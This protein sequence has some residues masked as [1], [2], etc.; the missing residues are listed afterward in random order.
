M[1][2]TRPSSAWAVVLAVAM[3]GCAGVAP[4]PTASEPDFMLL[5]DIG[6]FEGPPELPP[7]YHA[8]DLDDATVLLMVDRGAVQSLREVRWNGVRWEVIAGTDAALLPAAEEGPY[9]R[10][11]SIGAGSGFSQDATLLLARVPNGPIGRVE[12]EVD[13]AVRDI[14]VNQ[15]PF[16]T[17]FP[18][19]TVIGDEFTALDLQTFVLDRGIVH[20]D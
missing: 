20:H 6:M 17:V 10:T 12:V 16:V 18:A 14:P 3:T 15:R 8:V 19:G 4:A 2:P 5:A 1:Q 7:P 11:F 9:L 13:G